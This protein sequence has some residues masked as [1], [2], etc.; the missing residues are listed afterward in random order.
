M[1]NRSVVWVFSNAG[2]WIVA[3]VGGYY[4]RGLAKKEALRRARYLAAHRT[5]DLRNRPVIDIVGEHGE[6]LQQLV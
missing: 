1:K 3:A 6:L 4:A 5:T 2:S